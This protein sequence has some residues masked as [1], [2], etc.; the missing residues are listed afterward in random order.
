[1]KR[2][3]VVVVTLMGNGHLYPVLPLIAELADRGYR[4][5][6]PINRHYAP[7]IQAA[8]AEAVVYSD[9]PVDAALQAE[10]EARA[11]LLA[12]DPSRLETSDLEWE[13]VVKST[14]HLLTQVMEFYEQDPPDLI[15]YNRYSIAGRVIAS[16]FN[17]LAIQF[18]PHFAYPGRSRFW[19][20]GDCRNPE[21]MVAYGKRLDSLMATYEI[22][23]QDNLWHVEKLNI[24]FI[25]KDFQYR[26]ELFDD[27]FL[28]SGSLLQR[29]YGSVWHRQKGNRPLILI[30]GYS[31]LPETKSS[32]VEYF[33]IFIDALANSPYHCILS[34]GESVPAESLGSLPRNFE[35]NRY[36]SHLEI[37][38]HASLFACHGGMGSS[39]EAL[40]HGVPV[41]AIPAS[42]YT[43]EV[44]HRIAELGVGAALPRNEL[45]VSTLR[46]GVSEMLYSTSLQGRVKALQRSFQRSGGAAAVVQRIERHLREAQ[47]G[48]LVVESKGG[49]SHR[50]EL[51]RP[52]FVGSAC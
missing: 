25:P 37:L 22:S 44:A 52:C 18:S 33:K 48:D 21:G 7:R 15:L 40:H 36:A 6:C 43:Q 27:R 26:S 46:T 8:G 49:D 47:R 1:M 29:S 32:D 16:R 24:H 11:S 10:N 28:F 5:S 31:G 3:H 30:S 13:H 50:A 51:T 34:I 23:T 41:L 20:H 35:I 14:K 17:A 38:P 9:L 45:D 2:Q 12:S 39:L 4:V 42:P 19:C